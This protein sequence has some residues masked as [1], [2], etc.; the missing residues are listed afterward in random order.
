MRRQDVLGFILDKT[1]QLCN[2]AIPASQRRFL[3]ELFRTLLAMHGRVTFTN[4]ARYSHLCERTFRRHFT[5]CVDWMAFNLTLMHLL[6]HPQEAC[7]G[8]LDTTFLDKAGTK[9]YGLDRFFSS[10]YRRARRGLEV[11]LIGS[12]GTTTRRCIGLAATQTPAGLAATET[13]GPHSR[14]DFYVDQLTEVLKRLDGRVRYWV[15]DGFY[16]KAKF[17]NVLEAHN[18]HLITRLRS[19]ANL[20]FL[21]R[22]AERGPT[23][24]LRRYAGKVSFSDLES[25]ESRFE[26]VGVLED[27]PEVRLYTALVNSPHFK[28]D[29]RIVVLYHTGRQSYVVLATTDLEQDAHEVVL[30]FRLRFQLE[31]FIRDAKQHTGL[32][33]CQARSQ[34]KLDF[35]FNMSVAGV[36]LVRLLSSRAGMSVRSY[37]QEQYNGYLVDRLRVELGLEAELAPSRPAVQRVVQTGRIAA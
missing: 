20:R 24:R 36:N 30:F 31:L 15:G 23:G 3:C 7:I 21:A 14:T 6:L 29:L 12:V 2:T 11:L 13:D 18:R 10:T 34:A 9:T 37:I 1:N 25:P 16:A 27:L 32:G 28:R 33:H 26:C 19:D 22:D 4:M 35:H 17:F 8:V 5:R